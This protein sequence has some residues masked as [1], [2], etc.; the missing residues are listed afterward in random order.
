M[1][2]NVKANANTN[3]AGAPSPAPASAPAAAPAA[4]VPN[5]S[6]P[7][8]SALKNGKTRKL[9]RKS[10]YDQKIDK[11]VHDAKECLLKIK[12]YTYKHKKI[13]ERLKKI[14]ASKAANADIAKIK[15]NTA[16]KNKNVFGSLTKLFKKKT[17]F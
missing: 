7:N 11:M 4:S 10:P 1:S 5:A 16:A 8:A 2:A 13:V 14:A 6:V 15:A 12:F 9:R 17:T 3:M